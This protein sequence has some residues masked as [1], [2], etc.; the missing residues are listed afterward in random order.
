MDENPADDKRLLE[1]QAALKDGDT[2]LPSGLSAQRIAEL[3]TLTSAKNAR[4]IHHVLS[5]LKKL[6]LF[7]DGREVEATLRDGVA[8]QV[9]IQLAER[10]DRMANV[11]LGK[12][13]T[14]IQRE[15]KLANLLM[16]IQEA[17]NRIMDH[18]H[19]ITE[20]QT[21]C[22]IEARK[23]EQTAGRHND[24]MEIEREKMA[25]FAQKASR[26]LTDDELKQVAGRVN[27]AE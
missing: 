3:L 14:E 7:G 10:Y 12:D 20:H 16:K 2:R 22:A 21:K 6:R 23:I 4:M 15:E 18:A 17:Q 26:E 8:V 11:P 9:L 5:R 25:R 19:R 1:S 27:G 24:K 13:E